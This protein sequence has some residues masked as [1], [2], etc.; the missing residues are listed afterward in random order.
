MRLR[1][2]WD[3][4]TPAHQLPGW[5][6]CFTAT[7]CSPL[8]VPLR[9]AKWPLRSQIC[10]VRLRAQQLQRSRRPLLKKSSRL[11]WPLSR[12]SICKYF[13]YITFSLTGC[14]LSLTIGL[15]GRAESFNCVGLTLP[16]SAESL[17]PR[18]RGSGAVGARAHLREALARVRRQGGLLLRHPATVRTGALTVLLFSFQVCNGSTEQPY[19]KPRAPVHI[20][21]GSAVSTPVSAVSFVLTVQHT[22]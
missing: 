14:L 16:L 3:G 20:I 2:A 4:P 7:V 11:A 8:G 6:I 5:K 9:A 19:V 18:R 13:S 22:L 10:T 12:R 1:S 15:V 17:L 21:T